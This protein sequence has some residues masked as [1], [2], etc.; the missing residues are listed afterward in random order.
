MLYLRQFWESNDIKINEYQGRMRSDM[1]ES[2]SDFIL[3]TTYTYMEWQVKS[4]KYISQCSQ[5][6]SRG[7]LQDTPD[8]EVQF[9]STRQRLFVIWKLN[10]KT[11]AECSK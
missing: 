9:V 1:I 8:Y 7:F 3:A 2:T 4:T 5:L 10:E 6:A 11:I